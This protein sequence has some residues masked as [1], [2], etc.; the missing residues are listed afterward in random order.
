MNHNSPDL[1]IR[2]A[3]GVGDLIASILHSKALSWIVKL[4]TKNNK[5]CSNCSKRRYALN[6]L[7]PIAFWK[8][9]FKDEN[10]YLE[11]LK[12]FYITCG[13]NASV[14][15]DNRYV[16]VSKFDQVPI[17]PKNETSTQSNSEIITESVIEPIIKT[18]KNEKEGYIFLSTNEVNLGDHLIKTQFYKKI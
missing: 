9:F 14:N 11:N 3:V 4:I 5:P 13:F 15:Y 2:Y 1:N 17:Y 8:L 18:D 12:D 16:S 6:V 10:L 7:F